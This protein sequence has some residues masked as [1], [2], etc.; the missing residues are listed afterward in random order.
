M[1]CGGIFYNLPDLSLEIPILIL[2]LI[3]L[4]HVFISC[5]KGKRICLFSPFE[6]SSY[7]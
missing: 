2:L 7:N 6:Y 4:H 3:T 1:G 5:I